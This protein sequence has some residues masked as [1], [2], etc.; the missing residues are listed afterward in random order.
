MIRMI[1]ILNLLDSE[2]SKITMV[3][4]TP[5]VN[6]I[7]PMI[8]PIVGVRRN[9]SNPF[10]L[11]A[12][13]LGS[14]ATYESKDTIDYYIFKMPSDSN[15]NFPSV[16]HIRIDGLNINHFT[17]LFDTYNNGYPIKIKVNGNYIENNSPTFTVGNL[18]GNSH[19]VYIE[20][21]SMPNYPMR[22]QGIF[23]G[24]EIFIDERNLIEMWSKRSD[25]SSNLEPAYGIISNLGFIKFLDFN[26]EI[27]DYVRQRLLKPNLSIKMYVENTWFRDEFNNTKLPSDHSKIQQI[28]EL[29][30][31]KWDYNSLNFEVS[32]EC[33]DDLE[34]WQNITVP[35]IELTPNKTMLDL[36][37]YLKSLT[38]S[39]FVFEPLDMETE[40]RLGSIIIDYYYLNKGNLWESYDKLC[41]R[42]QTHIYKNSVGNVVIKYSGGN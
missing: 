2:G 12:S 35:E 7:S 42:A 23:T 27:Q 22:I 38:P 3:G 29:V 4:F 30:T 20:N 41:Q 17:I 37:N 6:N 14:G 11:G 34:E 13:K 18:I 33:K 9:G 26:K 5:S 1:A 8:T 24:L 32:V 21:W 10:L 19:D 36:F 28:A 25:R 39:K 16:N 40:I 15:G 31:N